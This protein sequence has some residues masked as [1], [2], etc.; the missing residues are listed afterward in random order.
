MLPLVFVDKGAKPSAPSPTENDLH[1]ENEKLHQRVRQLEAQHNTPNK[2]EHKT[3]D[4][5]LADKLDD[6]DR[7]CVVCTEN[8]ATMA[9]SPCG[10]AVT[11]GDCS[12]LVI[13]CPMCRS[14]IKSRL[15]LYY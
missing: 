1:E 13:R 10:H 14:L 15:R 7:V 9:F 6:E 8:P 2:D 4:P 11:C 5:F 12:P 3:D